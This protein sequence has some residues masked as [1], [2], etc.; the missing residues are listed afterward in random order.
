MGA[1]FGGRAVV[2]AR[3][4][5]TPELTEVDGHALAGLLD[6][7]GS[8]AIRRQN[9]G[10]NWLCSMSMALRDDD[11][12]LIVKLRALTGLGT[13]RRKPARATS[14]PQ[15]VWSVTSG[16]ECLRL[17]EILERFPLRGRKRLE[18]QEWIRGVRAHERGRSGEV[19]EYAERLLR[20]RVYAEPSRHAYPAVDEPG[21]LWYFGGFFTGEGS[22]VLSP[23]RARTVVKLRRDDRPLLRAFA[24]LTGLGRV[25]DVPA[26]GHAS[27]AATWTIF[28]QP[29][30]PAA[31]ELLAACRLRGRKYREFDVWRVGAEEFINAR[32]EGRRRNMHLIDAVA[33]CLR[34]VRA[35]VPER[36]APTGTDFERKP[37][38]F[39]EVLRA[40]AR[41]DS[42]PLTS[43]AYAAARRTNPHW[44]TRDTVV[45][46]FGS[47][48]EALEAAGLDGRATSRAR[49]CRG[50]GTRRSRNSVAI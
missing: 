18:V 10:R 31:V 46:A 13:I 34:D 44:P 28:A 8:F 39:V 49:R 29:Q 32:R 45:L 33:Q 27:P 47:W 37:A 19:A 50:I 25:Y 38:A 43:T 1:R 3:I 48:I 14:K 11:A 35:Y 41:S 5:E 42:G 4:A 17:A 20:H 40:W 26:Y 36:F 2:A 21:L 22:F 16:L 30:L 23:S 7:E 6:A 9:G 12:G 24:E 15:A